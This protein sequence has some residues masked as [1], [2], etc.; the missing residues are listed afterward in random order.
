MAGSKI[1]NGTPVDAPTTNTALLGRNADDT[2]TGILTAASPAT[3]VGP[4]IDSI[5]Q[6]MNQSTSFIGATQNGPYNQI[7]SYTE[8]E[9]LTPD[10]SL[11]ARLDEISG[12]FNSTTGHTHDGTPG[13][14]APIDSTSV[15]S[16][17][18]HGYVV[19]GIDITGASGSSSDVSGDFAAAV[20]SNG[21]TEYGVVVNVPYNKIIIRQATGVDAG[22]KFID[23][24]GNEVY[25]RI[26]N[27]GGIGG[28]WTIDY[29]V[30]IAGVETSYSFPS[31]VNVSYYFQQLYNPITNAPVYSEYAVTPSENTTEDVVDASE[32]QAGKVL[33]SNVVA[34]SVGS[35]NVKGVQTR[36]SKEDHAH[37]G[38][39]SIFKTGDS[40]V[41]G[42]VELDV[43][44]NMTLTRSG[45][46][47]TFDSNGGLGFQ[48]VPTGPV[49]GSN[50]TFGPLSQLP[51]S[52]ESVLVF[53]DGLPVDKSK[54]T[55][56]G[57]T[58]IFTSGNAP[59]T[60]QDIYC[61]YLSGGTPAVPPTPTGTLVTEFRTLTA[62]EVS[63]KIVVLANTPSSPGI[64]L[65]DIIGGTSQ[66]FS[67]DY[68]VVTNEFRWNGYALDG[69][70]SVGDKIRFHYIT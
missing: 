24:S 68:T 50:L 1:V 7:P 4:Q 42:D 26:T 47:F 53:L 18:L 33:L 28:T 70:L 15:A 3:S 29:Y 56:S 16:V 10:V 39:H 61:F 5:Q 11:F 44:T 64:V 63:A 40:Q 48:E 14:G 17:V 25:G 19:R 43:G 6:S 8:N 2:F 36:V 46:K 65:V 52:V 9:G 22:D 38:V 41:Y 23:G 37:Q 32:T 21:Q 69:L 66:E 34:T 62:P 27:T 54:W 30:Q 57:Q 51:S 13:N 20:P 58:I 59:Y 49:N 55:L 35:T 45:N 60:G 31:P 12:K 67:V